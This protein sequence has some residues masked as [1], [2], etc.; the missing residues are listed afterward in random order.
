M[1]RACRGQVISCRRLGARWQEASGAR[2]KSQITRDTGVDL[3]LR[4]PPSERP[5]TRARDGPDSCRALPGYEVR[6]HGGYAVDLRPGD[7]LQAGQVHQVD[8]PLV[9]PGGG[10]PP[11]APA[12][13]PVA[14]APRGGRATPAQADAA[15]ARACSASGRPLQPDRV[16]SDLRIPARV[17]AG[18]AVAPS[19]CRLP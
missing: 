7:A 6:Q 5:S 9:P 17:G 11:V 15:R 13:A 8:V 14:P 12:P 4:W 19:A 16:V 10:A 2:Q 3:S 18:V 1:V